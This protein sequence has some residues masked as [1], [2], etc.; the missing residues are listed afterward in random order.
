ML[1]QLVNTETKLLPLP[2]Q[3]N[4][5]GPCSISL[6]VNDRENY[7]TTAKLG[8]H[9]DLSLILEAKIL[10]AAIKSIFIYY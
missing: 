4:L 5:T 1:Y 2:T 6:P 7:G 10:A 9:R 3:S 8:N